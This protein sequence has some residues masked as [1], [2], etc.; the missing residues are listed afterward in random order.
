MMR[1]DKFLSDMGVA[2]RKETALACRRGGVL[3]NG[4]PALR[5]EHKLE[6]GRD[7][8]HYL[9]REIV[10]RKNIYLWLNKPEG[11][12]SA[13]EDG[14]YPVVTA[15]A[16]EE[17]RGRDLFPCGRLDRDTVGLLLLTDDG[18]LAHALLSP[19][20]GIEKTY[21]FAVDVPLPPS[22]EAILEAGVTTGGDVFRPAHLEAD[23][24]RLGG[25]VSVT[26]GKYH[27]VK[28]MLASVGSPVT[29]LERVS[30]AGIPLPEDLPR[31]ACVPLT[32]EEVAYLKHCVRMDD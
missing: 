23:A 17:Y 15:L 11:Y 1:L 7:R 18:A 22:A 19:K 20:N 5:P 12:V 3:V 10:Y 30:F 27:E 21:R 6:P 24:D 29:A 4:A 26:E 28:R 2:S 14:R 13:T 8:V 9:G 16:P 31:G 25:R 32:E